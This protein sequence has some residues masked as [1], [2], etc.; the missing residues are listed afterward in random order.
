MRDV[1]TRR[2][3]RYA[4][5]LDIRPDYPQAH[6]NLGA[7]LL[8]RGDVAGALGHDLEAVRADPAYAEAH[9][10]LARAYA[11][12]GRYDEAVAAAED[13]VRLAPPEPLASA[14]REQLKLYRQGQVSR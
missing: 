5:A 4:R 12:E 10:N 6:N 1:W 8:Q 11:A 9:G 2:S 14:L 3:R 7:I 13:A